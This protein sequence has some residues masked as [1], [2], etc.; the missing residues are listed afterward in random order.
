M[1]SPL[2]WRDAV[3]RA[4]S[5]AAQAIL[6][7]LSLDGTGIVTVNM[8]LGIILATAGFAAMYAI[9]K[10]IVAVANTNGNS[11]SFTVDNVREK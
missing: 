10:A 11:A 9:L 8:N 4:I 7:L 2:F 6:T 1:L 3:E 5:T